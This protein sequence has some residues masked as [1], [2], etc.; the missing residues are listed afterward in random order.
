MGIP[1]LLPTASADPMGKLVWKGAGQTAYRLKSFFGTKGKPL[2]PRQQAQYEKAQRKIKA[3]GGMFEFQLVP[4]SGM[5]KA[6]SPAKKIY[7]RKLKKTVD[8]EGKEKGTRSVPREFIESQWA[9]VS[10]PA[11]KG[12]GADPK[13]VELILGKKKGTQ[14]VFLPKEGVYVNLTDLTGSLSTVGRAEQGYKTGR[15]RIPKTTNVFTPAGA[16]KAG[17]AVKYTDW[18]DQIAAAPVLRKSEAKKTF[19]QTQK[20][21][22]TTTSDSIRRSRQTIKGVGKQAFAKRTVKDKKFKGTP[23]GKTQAVLKESIGKSKPKIGQ[24]TLDGSVVRL[25]EVRGVRKDILAGKITPEKEAT[26]EILL[27]RKFHQSVRDGKITLSKSLSLS[28]WNK[29]DIKDKA[30]TLQGLGLA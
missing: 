8:A 14:K 23:R 9:M 10:G 18:L 26:K 11:E 15:Y 13:L 5:H 25:K 21:V 3:K 22:V 24:Q 4:Q 27:D 28:I 17:M 12:T 6:F 29:L 20:R 19:G 30:K 7:S 1:G 16:T 2:T